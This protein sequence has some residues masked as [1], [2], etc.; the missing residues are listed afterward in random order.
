[1]NE[2]GYIVGDR[3]R[4]TRLSDNFLSDLPEDEVEEL[5]SLIGQEWTV[6][7]WRGAT[8]H[9]EIEFWIGQTSEHCKSHTVW[10]PLNWIERI[11]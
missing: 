9:I 1:M 6:I 10:V 7:A 4:L 5:T 3:V 2:F 8:Q 11:N